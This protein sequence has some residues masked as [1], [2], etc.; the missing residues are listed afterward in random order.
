LEH[1]FGNAEPRLSEKEVASVVAMLKQRKK[2]GDMLV[3]LQRARERKGLEGPGK[4]AL[5][6]YLR[7]ETHD[8]MAKE[9]RGRPVELTKAML[10]VLDRVRLKLI[11]EAN[12]EYRVVWDDVL[13]HGKK[14]LRAKGL[15]GAREPMWNANWVSR[16]MR[17]ALDCRS[18]PAKKKIQRTPE[19]EFARLKKGKVWKK[20]RKSFWTHQGIHAYIDNKAFVG[21]LSAKNKRRMRQNRVV[22]HLRKPSEGTKPGFVAPK[23]NRILSGIKAFEITAAVAKDR[24]IMWHSSAG[25]WNGE[26]AK[27]MYKVLGRRLKKVW[28]NKRKFRVVEDG[29]PKGFQS[30]KGIAAKVA[31][32]IES[33]KLP[34]RSPEWMPLD[35]CLWHEIEERLYKKK[36]NTDESLKTF[37]KRLRLIALRL[38][39]PIVRKCLAS[40]HKRIRLTVKAKGKHIKID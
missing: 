14:E 35:F 6:D 11:R 38:P 40:M 28:G 22:S 36:R 37:K 29:D 23:Q 16:Q 12:N 20:K 10:K 4:S 7:G 8:P 2:P 18:R 33:W 25:P 34:P 39:R 9:T 19:D 1:T 32:K 15:L 27:D 30:G 24:I 21:A 26:T 3:S 13:E 5:Y 17:G 31:A